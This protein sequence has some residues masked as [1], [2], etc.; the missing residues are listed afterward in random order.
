MQALS[1]EKDDDENGHIDFITA[2]SVSSGRWLTHP[3]R[4]FTFLCS[5]SAPLKGPQGIL[6]YLP[7]LFHLYSPSHS[8]P[9][10]H[11][12]LHLLCFPFSSFPHFTPLPS[13]S[14]PRISVLKCTRSKLPTGTR[15]NA[16]LEGLSLL[17][18]RQQQLW[19]DWSVSFGVTYSLCCVCV[20]VCVCVCTYIHTYIGSEGRHVYHLC[21]HC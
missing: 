11:P 6:T 16:L 5:N 1:F 3:V 4:T 14:G 19:L 8:P 15:R 9:L 10:H 17:L 18:P 21:V 12:Q 13:L 2:A 7:L 20:C